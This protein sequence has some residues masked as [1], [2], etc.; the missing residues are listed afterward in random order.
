M[1]MHGKQDRFVAY[2]HGEWLAG[3]IP[4]VDARLLAGD[5]HLTI[6][7]RRVPEV[8]AWLLA[9]LKES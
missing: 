8:H 7:L 3:R 5:G 6:A 1:V 4:Q 9:K 2:A